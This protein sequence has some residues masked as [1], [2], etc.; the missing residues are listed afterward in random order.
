MFDLTREE[1]GGRFI[2]D[3]SFDRFVFLTMEVFDPSGLFSNSFVTVCKSSTKFNNSTKQ[4]LERNNA[5]QKKQQRS[6]K[7]PVDGSDC[8]KTG[9]KQN[10]WN[11]SITQKSNFLNE[12]RMLIK[13][14]GT[15]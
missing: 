15:R 11:V 5:T 8:D 10:S 1:D 3:R 2:F 12:S 7:R 9:R 14:G 6:K 4:S 13:Y